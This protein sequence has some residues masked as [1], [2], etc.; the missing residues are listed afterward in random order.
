MIDRVKAR[1]N[2]D[3]IIASQLRTIKR[4]KEKAK[5]K[6]AKKSKRIRANKKLIRKS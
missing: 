5:E 6:W 2:R 4:K 1:E 3:E